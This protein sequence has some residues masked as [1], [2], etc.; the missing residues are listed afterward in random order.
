MT[1]TLVRRFALALYFLVWSAIYAGLLWRSSWAAARLDLH[2]RKYFVLLLL[3]L[4]PFM[5]P[6]MLR[7]MR[8]ALGSWRQVILAL[9][10]TVALLFMGYVVALK[11]YDAT[12]VYPFHPFLQVPGPLFSSIPKGKPAG[13]LRI[14]ALGGSTTRDWRLQ[15]QDRYPAVLERVLQERY[16]KTH[17]EVLN[18]GMDWYSSEHALI[19]Y[20]SWA[21]DWNPDVVMFFEA[22][23]DIYRSCTSPRF[24]VGEYKS[25]YSHYYGPAINAYH[26]PSFESWMI[27]WI[28]PL[29]YPDF[30]RQPEPT[31]VPL[32]F[33]Q[34]LA[35]HERNTRTLIRLV[36]VDGRRIVVGTQASLFRSDLTPEEIKVLLFGKEF[37]QQDYKYPNPVSLMRAMQSA[38]ATTRLIAKEED[39]PLADID[40]AVPKTLEFFL[41]DVHSKPPAA[42]IV[43]QT[44]A[45]TIIKAGYI[46]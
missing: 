40:A 34:S 4:V 24:A 26:T 43:A 12:R 23:N 7:R 44:V 46:Q 39:I 37:C 32:E 41:D 6:G 28:S 30:H 42:R 20:E 27:G 16:P 31:D 15:E 19:F 18:G 21:R 22:I 2:S 9:M 5:L 35:S 38:N 11:V 8:E 17:I 45:Q 25:D 29:W 1:A 13:T 3:G 33:F 10:P 14:L 36:R